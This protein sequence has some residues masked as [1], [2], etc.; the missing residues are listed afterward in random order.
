MSILLLALFLQDLN[1]DMPPSPI[2]DGSDWFPMTPY[3]PEALAKRQQG[4]VSA[5]LAIDAKGRVVGC[6]ITSSSGSAALDRQTCELARRNAR[7]VPASH[8]GTAVAGSFALRDVNW[9][10]PD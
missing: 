8:A 9:V 6:R 10:L 7:F 4:K 2:R 5:M 1:G 3:P